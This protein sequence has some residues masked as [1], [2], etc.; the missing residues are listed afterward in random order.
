MGDKEVSQYRDVK[1]GTSER[2]ALN[3]ARIFPAKTNMEELS[4][5]RS[6]VFEVYLGHLYSHII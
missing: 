3:I 2:V 6:E 4:P 5:S 1:S